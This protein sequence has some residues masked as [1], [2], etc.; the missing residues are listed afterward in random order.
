MGF[1]DGSTNAVIL[2]AVLTDK[3][4]QLLAEGAGTFNIVKFALADDEVNYDIIQEFGR[5]VGREKIEKLTPI[6]EANTDGFLGVKYRN[7][8]LNN[9]SL[10]ILPILSLVST[11]TSNKVTLSKNTSAGAVNSSTVGIE[12]KAPGGVII[13]TGCTDFSYSVIID[14]TFL[15][16]AGHIPDTI[17]SSNNATYTLNANDSLSPA[18]LSSLSIT[19]SA[20]GISND[21]FDTFSHI[22]GQTGNAVVSRT[23]QVSGKNS[24]QFLSFDVDII[25]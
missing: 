19:L 6:L 11:L 14:N 9:N 3:G 21:V 18:N 8:S 7:L 24:G 23:C 17:D 20:K 16:I 4:R 1:I 5:T 15:T 22:D 13:D 2:D 10:T 25:K 12:Q